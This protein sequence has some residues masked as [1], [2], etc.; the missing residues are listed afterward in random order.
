MKKEKFG[1]FF[2]L[3]VLV[4]AVVAPASAQNEGY[5]IVGSINP[6][7]SGLAS[8]MTEAIDIS[9]VCGFG[10]GYPGD[11]MKERSLHLTIPGKRTRLILITSQF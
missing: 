5:I 3:S 2:F 4:L 6:D 1:I 10:Y 9:Q 8:D 11:T 7:P